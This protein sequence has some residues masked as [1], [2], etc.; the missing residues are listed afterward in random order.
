MRSRSRPASGQRQ[1]PH[2]SF[3]AATAAPT[4]PRRGAGAR[5][6]ERP[7]AHRSPRPARARRGTARRR[8]TS[9]SA[10]SV[11]SSSGSDAAAASRSR[12][13]SSPATSTVERARA[14]RATSRR[15]RE[16]RRLVL[17]EVAVVRE[18]QALHRREQPGQPA[19]RGARLA[20]RE[21]GDVRVQLLRHHRRPRR[22]RL[23]QP[24]EAELRASSRGTSSSPMRERCVKSTAAA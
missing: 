11:A 3:A 20:A 15:A 6:L 5:R 2:R 21:L 24:R 12:S 8:V 22:G 10:A 1:H 13:N 14:R 18:R 4:S 17:L 23:G 16:H 19:D 7:G 9:A